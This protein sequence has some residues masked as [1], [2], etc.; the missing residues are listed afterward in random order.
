MY[1]MI[2]I[3]FMIT[4]RKKSISHSTVVLQHLSIPSAYLL[5][6]VILVLYMAILLHI[7]ETTLFHHFIV[8][9]KHSCNIIHVILITMQVYTMC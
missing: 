2:K 4:N 7:Y 5:S 3:N 9:V 8:A 1:Q 6:K